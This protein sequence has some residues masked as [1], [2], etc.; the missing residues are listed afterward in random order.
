MTMTVVKPGGLVLW[1]RV[2]IAV[3]YMPDPSYR[4]R[5]VVVS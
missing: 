5:I 2:P 3:E 1:I 4:R